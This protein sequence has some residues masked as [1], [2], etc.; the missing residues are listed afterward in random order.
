MPRRVEANV[1]IVAA[2][3][4]DKCLQQIDG[5]DHSGDWSRGR[6]P[7]TNA[8]VELRCPIWRGL[9]RRLTRL[10]YTNGLKE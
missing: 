7:K 1:N 5:H 10:G 6:S 9:D 3:L 4:Q 2:R 8:M